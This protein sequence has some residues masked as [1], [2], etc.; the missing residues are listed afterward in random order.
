MVDSEADEASW[1]V[2]ESLLSWKLE[3]NVVEFTYV[4]EDG[5]NLRTK[6]RGR[7]MST[8]FVFQVDAY[9]MKYVGTN[10]LESEDCGVTPSKSPRVCWHLHR[11]T[12]IGRI[13]LKRLNNS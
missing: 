9:S 11:R 7:V 6:E 10:M 3:K 13:S 12:L 4:D 8:P 5:Y 2:A 1:G